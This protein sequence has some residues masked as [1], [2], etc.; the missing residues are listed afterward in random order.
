MHCGFDQHDGRSIACRKPNAGNIESKKSEVLCYRDDEPGGKEYPLAM[1][2]KQEPH[3]SR[4]P[5]EAAID[6]IL[7]YPGARAAFAKLCKEGCEEQWLRM[8][9]AHLRNYEPSR[10]RKLKIKPK[11]ARE[12]S[13]KVTALLREIDEL[14]VISW[15]RIR[16]ARIM[17]EYQPPIIIDLGFSRYPFQ[18]RSPVV[19]DVNLLREQLRAAA[20]YFRRVANL[21]QPIVWGI[22]IKDEPLRRLLT[23]VKNRTRTDHYNEVAALGTAATKGRH[24]IDPAA[25]KQRVHRARKR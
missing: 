4:D 23:Y 20:T 8:L 3:G 5:R 9:I 17:A 24:I 15:R 16:P 18:R 14:H 10:T 21:K 1:A 12:L 11:I 2:R 6:E 19:L 25:L 22:E 13:E 7:E